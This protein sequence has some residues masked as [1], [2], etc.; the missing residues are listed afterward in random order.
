MMTVIMVRIC[1]RNDDSEC[2]IAASLTSRLTSQHFPLLTVITVTVT[3]VPTPI[4]C[5][6]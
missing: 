2:C 5:I 6:A 1:W 4:P 3:A